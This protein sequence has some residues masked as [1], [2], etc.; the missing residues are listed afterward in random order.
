VLPARLLLGYVT[1]RKPSLS[2]EEV[3]MAHR[4][5]TAALSEHHLRTR[6]R[7]RAASWSRL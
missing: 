5:L 3:D 6:L 4:L 1:K 7:E 2:T